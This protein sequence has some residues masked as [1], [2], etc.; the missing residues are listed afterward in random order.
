VQE[1]AMPPWPDFKSEADTHCES[2]ADINVISSFPN[3]YSSMQQNL[4][5]EII[6]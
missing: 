6:Y 3:K 1:T 4:S 5:W 2:A